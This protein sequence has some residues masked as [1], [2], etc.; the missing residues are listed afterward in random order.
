MALQLGVPVKITVKL[1]G[2]LSLIVPG[3]HPDY[4]LVLEMQEGSTVT[5]L[6]AL[7]KV[8][9]SGGETVLSEG[10]LLKGEEKLIPGSTLEIFQALHGG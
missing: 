8:A 7:L 1:F 10:R 3:Y 6:M 4:G 9:H 5:D 2:P